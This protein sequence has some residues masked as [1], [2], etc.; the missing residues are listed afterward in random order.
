MSKIEH[1]A[2]AVHAAGIADSFVH[3]KSDDAETITQFEFITEECGGH[4]GIML[5]IAEAAEIMELFRVR[6]GAAAT[7]G[8]ELPYLYDVWDAI[9]QALWARLGKEPLKQLVDSAI[10]SVVNAKTT[11]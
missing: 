4:V 6:Q 8:G 11:S 7:W 3:V 1:A 5:Q 9:A 10:W 2:V